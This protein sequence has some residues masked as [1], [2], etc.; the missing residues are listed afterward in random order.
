MA[1]TP[2][3]VIADSSE[4]LALWRLVAEAKFSETPDDKDLWGSP[5]VH[6]LATRVSEA[7]L[8]DHQDRG[9]LAAVA[10]HEQ[11][12]DSLPNNVIFP[13][14][15][16]HLRRDASTPEWHALSLDKKV[17]Y[18]RGCVAPFRASQEQLLTLVREAEA[19]HLGTPTP[20]RREA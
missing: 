13:I 16:A 9:D 2:L 4:L 19:S 7:L 18:V 11:W 17:Q 12:L 10:A 5:Y 8:K 15:K 3:L 14:V 6:E 1:P 20:P